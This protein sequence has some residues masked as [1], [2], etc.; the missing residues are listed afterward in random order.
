[1]I[2]SKTLASLSLLALVVAGAFALGSFAPERLVTRGFGALLLVG[3]FGVVV[4]TLVFRFWRFGEKSRHYFRWSTEP[5]GWDVTEGH[6]AGG[7]RRRIVIGENRDG[8]AFD[9][10]P[11]ARLVL[12]ILVASI[13][14]LAAI[15]SRALDQLGS[16]YA[17]ASSATSSF[18]PEEEKKVAPAHDP[19]EPGCELVRRA[20]VLG[21]AKSLGDCAT[22]KGGPEAGEAGV[23][24]RLVC[25]R[26]Q[27]DEPVLH[28]W[29]RLLGGFFGN[30]NRST[31]PGFFKQSLQDFRR[32]SS[33]LA[34]LRR[35]E[36]EMLTAAPH[37]SHHIWT[38]LPS[39]GDDA[40]EERTCTSRYLRLP[41][42]PMPP[43]GSARAS[44]VFEHVMAQL[45]FEAT[46]DDAAA[47]CREYHVHWGAPVDACERLA[48]N[49]DAFL[50][51]DAALD[52]VRKTFERYQV[53]GDLVSLGGPKP[54]DPT[55]FLS[56]SC[57]IEGAGG[58]QPA[59]DHAAPGVEAGPERTSTPFALASIGGLRFKAEKVRVPPS[60]A[61]DTLYIDR[62]EAVGRLLAS[63]FRYGSFFSEAGLDQG[64]GEGLE[65]S[66][67]S[68]DFLLV[69]T[70]ELESI[71]IYLDPGWIASRPDLLDVY[72]Y[73]R[74]LKNFVALFRREYRRE[75]GRI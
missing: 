69:R 67:A 7:E 23:A 15:G 33:H 38:N 66:F 39:P 55:S 50:K 62:Y 30:V 9:L 63:G 29:W 1:V 2:G 35:S 46:Y 48:A 13:L 54:P 22:K 20:Y 71:D 41:H 51:G 34:A 59:R 58:A 70:Y 18:C 45:L 65:S 36:G 17:R 43:P 40:F 49:P 26:R 16:A 64:G 14:A 53:E 12:S 19:N 11:R 25:S 44:R 5:L 68:A 61:T 74:H 47:H 31:R 37:A 27:R 42:R 21:Y 56:F 10:S 3:C 60:P 8:E 72:P 6:F 57:Y 73:E 75:R 52:D 32:R 24:A 4:G 28:Y